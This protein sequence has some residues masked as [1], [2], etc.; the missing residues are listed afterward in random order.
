[1]V[2]LAKLAVMLTFLCFA[3]PIF[4]YLTFWILGALASGNVIPFIFFI[5]ITLWA[6]A[7]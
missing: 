4:L 2:E 3:V 7:R 5:V 6:I 1:M